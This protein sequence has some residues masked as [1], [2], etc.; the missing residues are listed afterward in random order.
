[1]LGGS[2]L[3]RVCFGEFGAIIPDLDFARFFQSA[4]FGAFGGLGAFTTA[5]FTGFT[6][7][8]F[9][10]AGLSGVTLFAF[11]NRRRRFGA[12]AAFGSTAAAH[13]GRKTGNL[14]A[15]G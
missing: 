9:S 11:G 8:A 5:A 13:N 12:F 2:G 14:G 10:P 3:G 6:F 4:S 15:T 7:G 1:M